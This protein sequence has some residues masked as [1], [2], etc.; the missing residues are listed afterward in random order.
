MG[1]SKRA[2]TYAAV[3][4]MAGLSLGLWF[5]QKPEHPLESATKSL[6]L[7]EKAALE[8][9]VDEALYDV[10][11]RLAPFA[12]ISS[13]LQEELAQTPETRTGRRTLL[14]LRVALISDNPEG[15]SAIFSQICGLSPTLCE[16]RELLIEAAQN[17]ARV[18]QLGPGN[19]L[20]LILLGAHHHD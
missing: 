11:W 3:A 7:E 2:A 20:P 12:T 15:Q 14:L 6:P 4:T 5:G 8:R 9:A 1:F 13:L 18:R 17:E 16:R 10:A 19:R